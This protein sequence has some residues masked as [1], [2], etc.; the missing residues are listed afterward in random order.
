M[1]ESKKIKHKFYILGVSVLVI[2]VA[3]VLSNLIVFSIDSVAKDEISK[4]ET[5][6]ESA[7]VENEHTIIGKDPGNYT[8]ITE[9][10]IQSTAEKDGYILYCIE[11]GTEFERSDR[12]LPIST[13]LK[14][15]SLDNSDSHVDWPRFCNRRGSHRNFTDNERETYPVLRCV[16][17]HYN[18]VHILLLIFF[19]CLLIL[20]GYILL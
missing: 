7:E 8:E 9:Y 12:N 2:L 3:L 1:I 6:E 20:F 17:N 14:Y 16:N 10:T 18:L 11:H 13:A 5:E 4:L 19:A 15:G